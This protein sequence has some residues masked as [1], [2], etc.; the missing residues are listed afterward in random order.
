MSTEY[1]FELAFPDRKVKI[2]LRMI[3]KRL[4]FIQ[5]KEIYARFTL[6]VDWV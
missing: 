6:D 5:L 2:R 4:F 1:N 3:S